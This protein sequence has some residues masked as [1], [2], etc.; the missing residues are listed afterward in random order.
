[1]YGL[2]SLRVGY[3]VSSPD[4][5]SKLKMYKQPFNTNNFAQNAALLAL[6]DHKFT[7]QSKKNNDIAM[8]KL[9]DLF[10]NYLLIILGHIV[11]LLLLELVKNQIHYLNI[12]LKKGVIVRPLTN[13]MLTDYLRVSLRNS[14]DN[15]SFY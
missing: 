2:A 4:N 13:Y 6:K 15:N 8:S 3:G 5:I 14:Q 1:M 10:N 9:I 7:H 11:T 12:F